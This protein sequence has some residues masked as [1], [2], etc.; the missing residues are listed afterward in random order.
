MKTAKNINHWSI[1]PAEQINLAISQLPIAELVEIMPKEY[2]GEAKLMQRFKGVR[3][4]DSKGN[5][6]YVQVAGK[7]YKIVQHGEAFRPIIEGIT[8]AGGKDFKFSLNNNYKEAD[9]RIYSGGFGYDTVAIGWRITNSFCGHKTLKYGVDV[10]RQDQY[11]EL[12]GYRKACSNGML[13]KVPLNDA[14]IIQPELVT[15]IRQ[16]IAD[17]EYSFKHSGEVLERVKSVQYIAE[18]LELLQKPMEALI[19]KAGKIKLADKKAIKNAIKQHV[20]RRYY[21]RVLNQFETEEQDVWGLYNAITF[22]ASHDDSI[23]ESSR[24]LLLEKAS[25]MLLAEIRA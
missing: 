19:K 13:V 10:N 16:K 5:I 2:I 6:D 3:V 22:V 9:L 21:S 25:N 20:G 11:I 14:E 8:V 24:G 12:V 1:K 17:A 18:A 7:D 4:R 15:E 23:T